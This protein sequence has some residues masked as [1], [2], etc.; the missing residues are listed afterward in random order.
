MDIKEFRLFVEELFF[1][2]EDEHT[3]KVIDKIWRKIPSRWFIDFDEAE[4]W[5]D[6]H[7]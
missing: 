2:E 7:G 5:D 3:K 4:R 6:L 1:K